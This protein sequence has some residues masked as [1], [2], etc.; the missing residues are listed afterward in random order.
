MASTIKLKNGS[1]APTTGDLVQGEP[2]LDLT[3]KRLYTENASGVVIEV[4][5]NPGEDVTFADNRK[6][7]FGAGSD[8]EIYHDGTHSFIKDAGTGHLKIQAT[9]L[10]LQDVDGNNYIDC[11]DGSYVRLMHNTATKLETT[12][13]GIDVTGTVTADGLTVDNSATIATFYAGDGLTQ[14]GKITT[15]TSNGLIIEGRAN[16]NLTFKSLG[17]AGGEGFKFLDSSNNNR[18]FVDSTTG[19]LSLYEDTGTTAKFFWDASAESLGIGTSSPQALLHVDG[20]DTEAATSQ[21]LKVRNSTTGEAV[22]IGLYAKADNGGDGNCGS[23]TFDAGA[24]GSASNNLLKLS[25]DHQTD[26][27]PDMVITGSGNVGIGTSSSPDAPLEVTTNY[28]FNNTGNGGI[29]VRNFSTTNYGTLSNVSGFRLFADAEYYGSSAHYADQTTSSG[30]I[31]LDGTLRFCTNTG[32]TASTPFTPTERAR[33]DSSGNLLVGKTST[34]FSTEGAYLGQNGKLVSTRTSGSLLALNRLTTDGPIAEFYKDGTV[35]GSIGTNGGR[36]YLANSSTGGVGISSAGHTIAHDSAGGVPDATNDLGIS[37]VRWRNLYLSGG[38][39]S[40][41]T[42]K[43][44]VANNSYGY[45]PLT[46]WGAAYKA[47]TANNGTAIAFRNSSDTDIGSIQTTTSSTSYNTSSDYRLKEN[48]VAMDN[49]SDRVLALNPV[50]FNFIADPDKTVD[51]FLAHEAQEVVPEAV[52]GSKDAMRTEEYEV[53]PAV[54][55]DDGNVVTEAVMGTR[56]VPDYQGIDQSKLV[57]LLTK[58]LQEALERIAVLESK[59]GA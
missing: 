43:V 40:S 11:I 39:I 24:D 41:L 8:L 44:G 35:V 22:T 53:S 56:E 51:G 58:A 47:T 55:D 30:I 6:A 19:N 13:T 59:V 46:Q 1:G 17:N 42:A 18:L 31:M 16:N 48:V 25:A 4:G 54:L 21:L 50:R 37:S 9:N 27:T 36:I 5:T 14:A 57:P 29:K 38:T 33:L 15:D 7:V 10:K 28:V 3:N 32:L 52:T 2:A 12:A 26:T 45:S 34:S 20:A 49:A 23:I